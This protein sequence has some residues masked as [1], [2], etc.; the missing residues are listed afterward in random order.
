MTA[1]RPTIAA[2]G[3]ATVAD[4]MHPQSAPLPVTATVA[5]V[6]DWFARSASRRLA[7]IADGAGRYMGSLTRADL[8]GGEDPNRPAVEVACYEPTVGPGETA[9]AGRDR[10]LE[11]PARRVPVIDDEG[12]LVGV[13]A[14]TTDEQAFACR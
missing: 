9:L 5:D 1:Q 12:Q 10:V 8:A 14:V 7:L 2:S 6:S 11:T 3:S 4:V 13:L